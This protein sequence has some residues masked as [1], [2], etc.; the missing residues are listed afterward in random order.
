M[1]KALFSHH[2]ESHD[3]WIAES[4]NNNVQN[5]SYEY[6]E[7]AFVILAREIFLPTLLP[8]I[9]CHPP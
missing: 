8:F 7:F 4:E 1:P 2:Q 6:S 3:I 9:A 5:F